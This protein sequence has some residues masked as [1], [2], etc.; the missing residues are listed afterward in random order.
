M[1]LF[2][3]VVELFDSNEDGELFVLAE[4]A[5]LALTRQSKRMKSHEKGILVKSAYIIV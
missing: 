1:E 3:H 4:R 5:K 2:S